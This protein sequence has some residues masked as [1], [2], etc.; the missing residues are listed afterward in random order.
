[1]VPH[2]AFAR[3]GAAIGAA[4]MHSVAGSELLLAVAGAATSHQDVVMIALPAWPEHGSS[5]VMVALPA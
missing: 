4:W 3:L 5:V 1:M 2:N